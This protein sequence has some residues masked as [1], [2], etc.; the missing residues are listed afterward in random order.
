L[1]GPAATAL[2]KMARRRNESWPIWKIASV[3]VLWLVLAG[4][5]LWLSLVI[6]SQ[7]ATATA[8]APAGPAPA[9][10]PDQA[11]PVSGLANLLLLLALICLAMAVT[12]AGW[13][14]YRLYLKIPPWRRRQLFGRRR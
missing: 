4:V 3:L 14:A 9:P 5:L 8:P 12:F 1:S 11:S 10:A 2:K 13:L 6:S 7:A